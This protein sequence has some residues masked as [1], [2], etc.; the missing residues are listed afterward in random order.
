MRRHEKA[1]ERF[2]ALWDEAVSLSN[3]LGTEEK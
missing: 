1:D 3:K 2:Q